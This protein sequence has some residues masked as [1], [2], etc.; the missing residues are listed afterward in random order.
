MSAVSGFSSVRMLNAASRVMSLKMW[1]LMVSL[2]GFAPQCWNKEQACGDL[3]TRAERGMID[4]SISEL[5]T[6]P[7]AQYAPSPN[8]KDEWQSRLEEKVKE[9]GPPMFQGKASLPQYGVQ[10]SIRQAVRK[11]FPD[12]GLLLI[13]PKV[14]WQSCNIFMR[15][16]WL[17]SRYNEACKCSYMSSNYLSRADMNCSYAGMEGIE[18]RWLVVEGDRGSLEQQMWIHQE[19]NSEFGNLGLVLY[20]GGKSLHAWYLVEGMTEE[21]RFELFSMAIDLGIRDINTWRICQPVRLPNGWNSKTCRKQRIILFAK[22][23]AG[24]H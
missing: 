16:V 13:T 17:S 21:Q 18:R 14:K 19:L 3:L 15:D 10:I 1:F 5:E 2:S 22:L 6:H 8:V 20:S 24:Y 4:L 12:D 23:T 9:A 7:C 11:L